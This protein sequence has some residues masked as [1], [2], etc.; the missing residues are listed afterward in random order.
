MIVTSISVK[1]TFL[2]NGSLEEEVYVSQPL[3]FEVKV[4]EDKMYK[5]RKAL[6]GLK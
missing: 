1:S 6:Y 4:Q 2:I 5:L 3:G